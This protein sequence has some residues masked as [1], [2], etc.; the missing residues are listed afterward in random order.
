MNA[1]ELIGPVMV[2]PSSSHT[3]GAVRIGQTAAMLLGE[4]PADAELLLSGSFAATGKGHG[5]DRA[6]VAGLLG[7]SQDDPKIPESFSLAEEYGLSFRFGTVE[8]RNAHPNT[9]RIA[10]R[11]ASGNTVRVQAA[12]V[13]GGSI[14]VTELDGIPVEFS[15]ELETLV[16]VHRDSVGVIAELTRILAVHGINIASLRCSRTGKGLDAVAAVEADGSI[17]QACLEE[18]RNIS[19][20]SRCVVVRRRKEC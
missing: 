12:S 5:T 15:G 18:C 9:V 2:G 16:A 8:L 7:L 13:G 20:V 6:L 19:Q 17:T 1:L 3:A 11:A 10:L 4:P 14:L